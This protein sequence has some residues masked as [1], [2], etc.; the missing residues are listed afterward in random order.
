MAIA[1][2]A[3][4]TVASGTGAISPGLPAGT[5]Y[6]DLLVMF[7]ETANGAAISAA[8]WT[9]A[10]GSPQDEATD[11]TRLTVLWRWA[12]GTSPATTTSDS[13]NHQIGRIIGF[14]GCAPWDN[15]SP[16]SATAGS[17]SSTSSTSATVPGVTTSV[18]N[19]LLIY[20]I[21]I[22]RDISS[23]A[24]FSGWTNAALTSVTEQID[25]ATTSG[26]GGGIGV[27]T[28]FLASPGAAGNMTATLALA[29]RKNYWCGALV[30]SVAAPPRRVMGRRDV[31]DLVG[32]RMRP[33]V[34][35][36]PALERAGFYVP[37]RRL[38]VPA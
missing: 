28:G 3:V 8:G 10:P 27:A 6:A 13:G 2:R 25:N 9:Q 1:V 14:S 36:L 21:G 31:I 16:F 30:P 33:L 18:A 7:L 19:Q 37:D 32:P 24:E 17:T 35:W 4:G 26:T 12:E 22:T 11:L 29:G 15:V 38:L 5:V 34:G 23:T 20:A